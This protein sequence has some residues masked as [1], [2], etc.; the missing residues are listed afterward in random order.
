MICRLLLRSITGFHCI[1][2]PLL[3]IP[4]SLH[5]FLL[6]SE[7]SLEL[8]SACLDSIIL[9]PNHI[10]HTHS[11]SLKL[12]AGIHW[13]CNSP[14][15]MFLTC[16]G[17]CYCGLLHLL[18]STY[19]SSLFVIWTAGQLI[20]ASQA[21]ILYRLFLVF[22]SFSIYSQHL[23]FIQLFSQGFVI[24]PTEHIIIW[25]QLWS[26]TDS[27]CQVSSHGSYSCLEC[28]CSNLSTI[29]SHLLGFNKKD[30]TEEICCFQVW[31]WFMNWGYCS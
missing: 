14:I 28:I 8:K 17:H 10:Q 15:I 4:I 23:P 2:Q 5:L 29:C 13:L 26:F 24:E 1:I 21:Y 12:A 7:V 18:C 11:H 22:K 9:S 30:K 31:A 6:G 16:S 27:E 3:C 19:R 20:I 25:L